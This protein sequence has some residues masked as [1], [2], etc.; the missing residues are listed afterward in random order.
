MPFAVAEKYYKIETPKGIAFV[1]KK[2]NDDLEDKMFKNIPKHRLLSM[3]E[4]EGW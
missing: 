2:F 3:G 4:E 1:E